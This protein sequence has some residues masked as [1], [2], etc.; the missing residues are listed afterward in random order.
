MNTKQS[1]KQARTI[2]VI[3][4]TKAVSKAFASSISAT[5]QGRAALN[6]ATDDLLYAIVKGMNR[7]TNKGDV[8][9]IIRESVLNAIKVSMSDN[10]PDGLVEGFNRQF[11]ATTQGDKPTFIDAT[12]G[13]YMGRQHPVIA[14]T[15]KA[16]MYATANNILADMDNGASFEEAQFAWLASPCYQWTA[17]APKAP[18]VVLPS[19]QVEPEAMAKGVKQAWDKFSQSLFAMYLL[20]DDGT[21][22][23]K[24]VVEA[25]ILKGMDARIVS[26]IR[27]AS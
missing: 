22:A 14:G 19:L 26:Q 11:K 23:T 13:Y 8:K 25:R 2:E 21:F 7:T 5:A 6:K 10:Y 24:K 3:S 27:K 16:K 1:T 4:V 9:S 12:I 17:Q 20:N 15:L 18:E